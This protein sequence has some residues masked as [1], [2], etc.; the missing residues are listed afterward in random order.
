MHTKIQKWGNSQGLRLAKNVIEDAC[1]GVGDE[2]DVTVQN[3]IIVV[4]PIRKIRGRYRLEDLVAQIPEDYH[5]G[6]VDW[7]EPVGKEVW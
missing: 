3:G 7:G 2:V 6:E 4:A 5:A 1:L